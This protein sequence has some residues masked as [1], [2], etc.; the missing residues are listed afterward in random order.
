MRDPRSLYELNADVVVPTGLP[1]VAGLT[2][3]ADAGGAVAQT[4]EY[5]LSTLDT[6]VVATF[7]ADEL[8][9]YRARRPIILFEGDHRVTCVS[10][11]KGWLEI[12]T[13]EDY[14]RAWAEIRA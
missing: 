10:T 12:D 3:F 1:L 5:L 14:Q 4:T 8:L 7:D 2:G 6:T 13:F 11:W 9:D